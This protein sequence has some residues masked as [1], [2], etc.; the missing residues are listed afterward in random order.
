MDY[1][2]PCPS[3]HGV[4][5]ARILKW[6]AMPSSKGSSRS[7]DPC[8][9][10]LHWQAGSLPLVPPWEAL[11]KTFEMLEKK[12]LRETLGSGV[13]TGALFPIVWL[14]PTH[15]IPVPSPSDETTIQLQL[16]SYQQWEDY[17]SVYLLSSYPVFLIHTCACM[18]VCISQGRR[19]GVLSAVNQGGPGRS[20][21]TS[22]E[23]S[24][25]IRPLMAVKR[26]EQRRRAVKKKCRED[27]TP[28]MGVFC[29]LCGVCER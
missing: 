8:L 26:G 14:C 9:S 25:G 11:S 6:V 7:R 2:S 1:N 24:D 23:H 20:L 19:E 3:V 17:L 13:G 15:G 28:G 4:L 27:W 5:Q 21:I 29:V 16:C 10:H 12:I 22:W 18:C